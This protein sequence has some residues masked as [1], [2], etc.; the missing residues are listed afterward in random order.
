[1]KSVCLKFGDDPSCFSPASSN[2]LVIK[3]HLTTVKIVKAKP[4]NV[5]QFDANLNL[6]CVYVPF[7]RF[8][9]YMPS[10]AYSSL[11]L[12]YTCDFCAY[13]QVFLVIICVYLWWKRALTVE[14]KIRLFCRIIVK[15][16]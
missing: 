3:F 12:K 10:I 13:K 1:M 15:A 2:H 11:Q 16:F 14:I 7:R 9:D 8:Q 4:G 5:S 6:L